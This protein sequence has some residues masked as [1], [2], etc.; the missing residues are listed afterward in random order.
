MPPNLIIT[1]F[2][3]QL[4]SF[5]NIKIYQTCRETTGNKKNWFGELVGGSTELNNICQ[6][7]SF[8]EMRVKIRNVWKHHLEKDVPAEKP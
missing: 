4:S 7:G 1:K 2:R 8:S 6:I 5:K 3:S